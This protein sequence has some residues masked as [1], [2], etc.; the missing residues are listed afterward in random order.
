M[1]VSS[2]TSRVRLLG[3]RPG[4]VEPDVAG[5][6]DAEDLEVDAAGARDRL[7]VRRAFR[8]DLARSTSPR[9]M[10]TFAGSMSTCENSFSHMNRWYECGFSGSIG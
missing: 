9:G 4:F 10:W 6:A 3:A 8:C 7:L 2:V 5:L 1:T